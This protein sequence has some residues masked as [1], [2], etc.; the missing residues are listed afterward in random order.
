[1]LIR[2]FLPEVSGLNTSA[3]A[4]LLNRR[5]QPGCDALM[6]FCELKAAHARATSVR[7][8]LSNAKK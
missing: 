2:H 5:K 8:I 6:A 7:C 1:M 3:M 4:I